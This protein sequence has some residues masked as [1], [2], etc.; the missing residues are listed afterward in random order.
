VR[1]VTRRRASL[2]YAKKP[3]SLDAHGRLMDQAEFEKRLKRA[4][5]R[6]ARYAGDEGGAAFKLDDEA[7]LMGGVDMVKTLELAAEEHATA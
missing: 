2:S 3:K 6:E 5:K 7:P 4:R 1:I